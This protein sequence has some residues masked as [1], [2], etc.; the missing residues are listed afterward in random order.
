[1]TKKM[2]RLLRLSAVKPMLV[3]IFFL[4]KR[5]FLRS[6]T[7]PGWSD[8]ARSS[9]ILDFLLFLTRATY[10]QLHDYPFKHWTFQ[11]ASPRRKTKVLFATLFRSVPD[12]RNVDSTLF[13]ASSFFSSANLQDPVLDEDP[14]VRR[15]KEELFNLQGLTWQFN[16]RPLAGAECVEAAT[17]SSLSGVI[18]LTLPEIRDLGNNCSTFTDGGEQVPIPDR[19]FHTARQ[20]TVL[21]S[22]VVKVDGQAIFV[23]SAQDPENYYFSGREEY[24]LQNLT[25]NQ[26]V[27]FDTFD[28]KLRYEE[29]VYIYCRESTN[30]FHWL[31]EVM[32]VAL[33]IPEQFGPK[34]AI[35]VPGPIHPKF[36]AQFTAMVPNPVIVSDRGQREAAYF[37]RLHFRAAP[38]QTRDTF[39]PSYRNIISGFDPH[40]VSA[41]RKRLLSRTE[42]SDF[43]NKRVFLAR[44]SSARSLV[45]EGQIIQAA[46]KR[47]FLAV[48]PARLS[49]K[50][51][52]LLFATAHTLVGAGGGVMGN[53][54]FTN[55]S[56]KLGQLVAEQNLRFPAPG[57][58]SQVAG[59]TLF[60]GVGKSKSSKSFQNPL[61]WQHAHFSVRPE[62]FESLLDLL[63]G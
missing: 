49:M 16:N 15:I 63:E 45:N 47:G 61:N 31:M 26:V 28:T 8:S 53:Y 55:P 13:H 21:P 22:G 5:V 50:E 58:I 12:L 52:V 51:Q 38:V 33:E 30:L 60:T 56:T 40:A 59:S 20:A 36:L 34:V 4:S 41:V 54:L 14:R 23:H 39:S 11:P 24:R 1:M 29:A 43:V 44:S 35:Y 48:D 2:V 7:N 42:A 62:V 37:D 6:L 19:S 3:L 25:N 9:K 10:R 27:V 46:E 17:Y 32:P 57:L 18:G